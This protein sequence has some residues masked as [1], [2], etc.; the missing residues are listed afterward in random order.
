MPM[1]RV[2]TY[3]DGFNLYFGLKTSG[4]RRY[5]W[6]NLQ[7]L[8]QNLL[9]AGQTLERTKYFTARIADPPD[10]QRRQNTY[11]EALGSLDKFTVYYGKYQLNPRQCRKCGFEEKVPNEKMTDV[12]LAVELLADAYQDTFD[13]AILISADSDLTPPI[14]MVKKLFPEKRIV[15]AF[16]PN[17]SSKELAKVARS[18]FVI[19]RGI[20]A[21]SVF[22]LEVRNPDGYI[23]KCPDRWK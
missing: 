21:K 13:T 17:R 3:I 2:I 15:I 8:S 20:F 6:L 19:G 16:P 10:K 1:E 5:Y 12:Q 14:V 18:H 9:R 11:L 23:L 22:P 4:W 7:L